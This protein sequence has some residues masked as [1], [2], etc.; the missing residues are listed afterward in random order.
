M[1]WSSV[2]AVCCLEGPLAPVLAVYHMQA[3]TGNLPCMK[4]QF[5]FLAV[6]GE[7]SE[8]IQPTLAFLRRNGVSYCLNFSGEADVDENAGPCT[9]DAENC[10]EE[11][12]RDAIAQRFL[13]DLNR[14]N[15]VEM[16]GFVAIKV[17][18]AC[19][20]LQLKSCEARQ[21]IPGA[22]LDTTESA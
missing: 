17:C 5:F 1:R 14:A 19:M 22:L 21:Q 9:T 3:I 18:L 7:C 15:N 4:D 12:E 16:T 8:E 11:Q 20:C 10:P 6:V 2:S 13:N